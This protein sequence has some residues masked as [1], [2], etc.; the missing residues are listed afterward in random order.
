MPDM[1]V[2][3]RAQGPRDQLPVHFIDQDFNRMCV[4]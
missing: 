1:M 2:P 3:A 4:W